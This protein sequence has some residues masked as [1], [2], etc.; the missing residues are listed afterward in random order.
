VFLAI[1]VSSFEKILF[2]SLAHFFIGSFILGEFSFLSS[3]YIL[4]ISPLSDVYLASIFSY[5]V[6]VLFSLETISFAEQ[7]LF[8]FMKSHL[9]MLSIAELLG[10]H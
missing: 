10:F 2:S 7:K 5:S 3:L 4:V 1:S 6:G 8:S 9:S